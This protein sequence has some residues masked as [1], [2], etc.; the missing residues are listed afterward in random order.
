MRARLTRFVARPGTH[1]ELTRL[2]RDEILPAGLALPGLTRMVLLVNEVTQAGLSMSLWESEPGTPVPEL[3]AG[4][5]ALLADRDAPALYDVSAW[6]RAG[7]GPMRASV[8]VSRAAAG[9]LD[10]ALDVMRQVILP[11]VAQQPGFSGSA[12]FSDAKSGALVNAT[13]WRAEEDMEAFV[14][15]PASERGIAALQRHLVEPLLA[16]VYTIMVMY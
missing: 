16:H 5:T 11:N 2:Y 1:A 3:T 10:Y 8:V 9:R 15:T 7:G 12:L 6:A 13:A 4:F 14:G